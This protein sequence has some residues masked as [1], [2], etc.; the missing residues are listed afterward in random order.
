MSSLVPGLFAVFQ[1]IGVK[2]ECEYSTFSNGTF[3]NMS[4]STTLIDAASTQPL[5]K[6]SLLKSHKLTPNYSVTLY[7][8]IMF[9]LLFGSASAFTF[10]HFSKTARR[11]RKSNTAQAENNGEDINLSRLELVRE[12]TLEYKPNRTHDKREKALL[13]LLTFMGSF[14]Q[15]GYLPGLLSYSTIPYGNVYFHLSINLSKWLL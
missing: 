1:S 11:V 13:L 2:D 7:F 6:G 8:I 14:I 10:L 9:V 15:Y 5:Q 3:A 12:D 4:M